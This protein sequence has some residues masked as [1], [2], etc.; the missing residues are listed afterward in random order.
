MKSS[1]LFLLASCILGT[2]AEIDA[3]K[4]VPLDDGKIVMHQVCNSGGDDA[5]VS[6]LRKEV[7]TLKNDWTRTKPKVKERFVG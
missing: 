2:L 4:L 5:E 7:E 3:K 1:S 6:S